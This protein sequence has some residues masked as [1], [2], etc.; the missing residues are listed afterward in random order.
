VSDDA[1]A[2][3]TVGEFVHDRIRNSELVVLDASGHCPHM[4]HPKETSALIRH[5]L[6]RL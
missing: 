1:I 6:D 3:R 4:T 2:P 5:F